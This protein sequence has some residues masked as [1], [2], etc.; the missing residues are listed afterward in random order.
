MFWGMKHTTD[1]SEKIL[2]LLPAGKKK[3]DGKIPGLMAKRLKDGRLFW[4]LKYKRVSWTVLDASGSNDANC[5]K[6]GH[7]QVRVTLVAAIPMEFQ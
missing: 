1:L 2:R 5:G 3:T 4:R 6:S 7:L